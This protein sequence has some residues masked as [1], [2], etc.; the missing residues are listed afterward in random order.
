MAAT[1]QMAARTLRAVLS[2]RG[3]D[4]A[5]IRDAAEGPAPMTLRSL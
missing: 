1:R 2:Y 5:E 4:S 3:G